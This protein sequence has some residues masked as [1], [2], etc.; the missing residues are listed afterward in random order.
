[1][2]REEAINYIRTNAT[3]LLSPDK[4]KRGY[5][6]PICSS[7]SGKN[8]TG[9][10]T[11]DKVHFTCWGG[12]FTS[13]DIFDIIALQYGI[14]KADFNEQLKKAVELFN[15]TIDKEPLQRGEKTTKTTDNKNEAR[16]KQET[17]FTDFFLKANENIS[18]TDYINKRGISIETAN[19][20]KI[21]YIENWTHPNNPHATPTPRIIFPISKYSYTARDTR[22]AMPEEQKAYKKQKVKGKEFVSWTFNAKALYEA[23]KPIFIVEGEFDALSIIEAGGVAVSIGSINNAENFIKEVEKAN[24][25]NPFIIALDNE[26][27][28]P[29]AKENVN[30]AIDKLKKGL[31]DLGIKYIEL[32]SFNGYKDANEN[33]IKDKKSFLKAVVDAEQE[34][35]ETQEKEKR[36]YL[37]ISAGA[38]LQNFR[39]G[40]IES[41]NNTPTP[42]GFKMLDNELDGGLYEGLYVIGAETSAGKTT[43]TLQIAD[44]IA[45]SEKDVLIFSLEMAREELMAR[46]ISRNTIIEM[47]EKDNNAQ[48]KTVREIL[49]GSLYNTYTEA[50]K[51]LI[52]NAIQRYSKYADN[53]Y[54]HEGVGDIGIRE[55]IDTVKK[56]ILYTGKTPVIVLDYLQIIAPHSERVTEKQAMDKA[57]LELKRISR[58]YKTPVIIISSF[59]RTSYGKEASLSSAKES[60][61]IEYSS[62]VMLGLYLKGIGETEFDLKEALRKFPQQMV[63]KILK[64]RN[65]RKG[66]EIDLMYYNKYNYFCEY[67]EVITSGKIKRW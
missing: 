35:Q 25:R 30:K 3:T 58:D 13:A 11:K 55:I 59:N 29:R 45:E 49:R 16:A 32:N 39:K 43:I 61:A 66:A 42:T 1:M 64:N 62:D 17:D 24:P 67:Q 60:G 37:Q 23:E 6:C 15:I 52:E 4:S 20:Y 47:L 19:K 65:G 51:T 53:I 33:L 9:I 28:N 18:S 31:E 7:G 34:A 48:P 63:L 12:C 36:E 50:E 46:S 10:T 2:K 8:G 21:G 41:I 44:N 56:H 38:N 54:I 5:I 14:D 27:D 26:T 22:E 57:V 40:I